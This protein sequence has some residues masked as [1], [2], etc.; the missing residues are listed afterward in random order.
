MLKKCEKYN[1]LKNEW[2]DIGDL[3]ESKCAFGAAA[4]E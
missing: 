4:D 3:N 2:E 1:I